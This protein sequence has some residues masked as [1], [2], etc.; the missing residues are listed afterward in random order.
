M[1]VSLKSTY[2]VRGMVVTV[3]SNGG[4]AP[5]VTRHGARSV[6]F[7]ANCTPC[8]DIAT[9]R[10]KPEL[11]R[12]IA[13]VELA[14]GQLTASLSLALPFTACNLMVEYVVDEEA[15]NGSGPEDQQQC[16][17]CSR[18]VD[19]RHGVCQH[20]GEVATQCRRC[21]NINY[22]DLHA[23]LCVEC[24]YCRFARFSFTAEL[25]HSVA[26]P[27]IASEEERLALVARLDRVSGGGCA[28]AGG[29]EEPRAVSAA[30]AARA[31]GS[32]ER[33]RLATGQ[34]SD[35]WHG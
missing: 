35:R 32:A 26:C 20:C 15:A 14:P 29:V 16:P 9:L 19:G 6:V 18:S 33:R 34:P 28:A 7:H 11:W 21:R 12:R 27:P 17:R 2:D 24:G 4:G 1:L 8:S 13:A 3:G 30:L 25:R 31:A 10:G 22:E 23:F 5:A